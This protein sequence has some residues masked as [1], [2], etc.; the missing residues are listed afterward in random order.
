MA[1]RVTKGQ[2]FRNALENTST[3][4]PL[5]RG[6]VREMMALNASLMRSTLLNKLIDDRRDIDLECGYPKELTTSQYKLLYDREGIATRVVSLFPEESWVVDPKVV[7]N[8]DTEESAFE[9][10]FNELE[11]KKQLWAYLAK[12]DEISGIG[13]YGILLLGLDDGKDLKEP[14]DGVPENG[15]LP[16]EGKATEHKL[17]YLRAFDESLVNIKATEKD[18]TNPRFGFPTMYSVKFESVTKT[19]TDTGEIT[20]ASGREQLVHWTRIIHLADNRKASEVYGVPRMQTLFN[21]LY[22][23]RKIAGGSGEMF[24]KGGFPGYSFEMDPN[25]RALTTT[26]KETLQDETAAYANGLQRYIRLQGITVNTLEPQVAD[27]TAHIDVNLNLIAI[28]L[29]VP[30]RVFMGSE[31]AKLA[32]SQD[33]K[34]W[35]KRVARRQNKYLTPY[36]IKPLIDRLMAAGVLPLVVEYEIQ[37]PDLDAPSEK[38]K[39]DVLDVMTQALAKYVGGNVDMLIPPEQ[40]LEMFAGLTKDQIETIMDAAAEREKDLEVDEE[41]RRVEEAARIEEEKRPAKQRR[42]EDQLKEDE[43]E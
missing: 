26:E 18:P 1:K 15:E 37:W 5:Q 21:R 32:S 22:D 29:G 20:P 2:V 35:N 28:A 40:Y 9:K 19:R 4:T 31:Q 13:C 3:L 42:L 23:I 16:T 10:A 11:E 6:Y 8:E 7:E 34:N 38:D 14:V 12:A 41:K 36:V 27:P 25:A 43:K 17:L 30:K 39:A 33:S 24:W